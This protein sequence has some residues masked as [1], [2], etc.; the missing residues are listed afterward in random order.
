[1]KHPAVLTGLIVSIALVVSS[2]VLGWSVCSFGRSL[3]RLSFPTDFTARLEGRVDSRMALNNQND[4]E[5]KLRL[6]LAN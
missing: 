5:L 4:Q 3:E 6:N 1:M 2:L